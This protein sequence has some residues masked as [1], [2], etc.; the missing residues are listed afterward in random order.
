MDLPLGSV[1]E[2][3]FHTPDALIPPLTYK[4]FY[5]TSPRRGYGD[6]GKPI[7]LYT[8]FYELD[9]KPDLEIHQYEISIDVSEKALKANKSLAMEIFNQM[10]EDYKDEYFHRKCYF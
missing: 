5:I 10:V 9:Y 8:N 7:K 3:I 6:Q 2:L 4:L 1:R